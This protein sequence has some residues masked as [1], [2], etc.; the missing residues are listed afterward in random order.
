M[1]ATLIESRYIWRVKVL[2]DMSNQS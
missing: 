2:I 1:F